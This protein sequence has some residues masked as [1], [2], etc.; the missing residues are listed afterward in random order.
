[1]KYNEDISQLYQCGKELGKGT[2]GEVRECRHRETGV[3]CAVKIV[4]K[5]KIN[6]HQVLLDLLA[7]ELDVLSKTD[8][9]N[10]TAIRELI[11]DENNFYIVSEL[12]NGGELYGKI[13]EKKR[14]S[15]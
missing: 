4:Q 10:I 1:L 3:Q 13:I 12:V 15:E 11:E 8:H 14:F 2:F 7:S 9:P 6:T 5:H